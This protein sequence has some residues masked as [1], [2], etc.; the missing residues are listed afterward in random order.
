VAAEHI[1]HAAGSY[2][3]VHDL[4]IIPRMLVAYIAR[5]TPRA[6]IRAM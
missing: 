5:M 3:G 2:S 6:F 1:V 4:Y